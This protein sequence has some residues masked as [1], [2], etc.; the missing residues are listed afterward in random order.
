MQLPPADDSNDN[1]G[2]SKAAKT[3]VIDAA[4][5]YVGYFVLVS[6]KIFPLVPKIPDA[7]TVQT[8]VFTLRSEAH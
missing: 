4:E 6:T 7:A 3:E 2:V 1:N 5:R 8:S